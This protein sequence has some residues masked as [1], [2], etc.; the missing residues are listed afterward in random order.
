MIHLLAPLYDLEAKAEIPV[1]SGLESNHQ[2][3]HLH[4]N[5]NEKI[6]Y[7]QEAKLHPSWS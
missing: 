1:L 7:A 5:C 2:A 6:Y 4:D 3:D